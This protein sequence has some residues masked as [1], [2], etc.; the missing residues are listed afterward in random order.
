MMRTYLFF[1]FAVKQWFS[2][3]K[4]PSQPSNLQLKDIVYP[5][6]GKVIEN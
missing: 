5:F 3:K 2:R 6:C 1:A 4:L